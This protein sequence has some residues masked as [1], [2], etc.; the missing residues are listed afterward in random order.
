MGHPAAQE[1]ASPAGQHE[2][3]HWDHEGLGLQAGEDP[4]LDGPGV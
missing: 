3:W 4:L 1:P 2:A